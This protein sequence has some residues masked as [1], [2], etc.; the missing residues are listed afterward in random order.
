MRLP[1]G[2]FDG[3]FANASLFHATRGDCPE[4]YGNC[5]KPGAGRDAGE[6]FAQPGTTIQSLSH[7]NPIWTA[8]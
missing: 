3:I 1:E 5:T 6:R 4:F 7:G 2:R 8:R